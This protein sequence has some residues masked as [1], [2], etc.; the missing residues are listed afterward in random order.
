MMRSVKLRKP[1]MKNPPAQ[2]A[3]SDQEQRQNNYCVKKIAGWAAH[4]SVSVS[5]CV[6]QCIALSAVRQALILK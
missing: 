2:A 5:S 1:A 4:H 6:S 3:Q